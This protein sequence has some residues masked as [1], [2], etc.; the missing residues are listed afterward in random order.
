L[1]KNNKRPILPLLLIAAGMILLIGAVVGIVF[2]SG[3]DDSQQVSVPNQKI[4]Y[5]QVARVDLST[6]KVAFDYGEAVFVDVRDQEYY[7]NGHIPGARS[8]PLGQFEDRL[9][10]LDPTDWIILYCT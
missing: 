10:E 2:I 9:N 5:P 8:I 4:P 6:A 1:G 3:G 7:K